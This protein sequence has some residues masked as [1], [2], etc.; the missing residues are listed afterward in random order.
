MTKYIFNEN[1]NNNVKIYDK[2]INLLNNKFNIINSEKV[3]FKSRKYLNDIENNGW[4]KQDV[5]NNVFVY[6]KNQYKIEVNILTKRL[7]IFDGDKLKVS[8]IKCDNIYKINR[9]LILIKE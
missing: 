4:I 3:K 1:N 9:I 8:D 6:T 7:S 5:I 2:V